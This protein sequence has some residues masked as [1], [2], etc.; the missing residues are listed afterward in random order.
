MGGR[1]SRCIGPEDLEPVRTSLQLAQTCLR[2]V[3]CELS[4]F[5]FR[6]VAEIRLAVRV[7]QAFP[8]VNRLPRL[9]LSPSR[10]VDLHERLELNEVRGRAARPP[11]IISNPAVRVTAV[12]AFI[13]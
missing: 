2:P 12:I 13:E 8:K 6:P 3:G 7:G 11:K 4:D 10:A 9:S 5:G 1:F